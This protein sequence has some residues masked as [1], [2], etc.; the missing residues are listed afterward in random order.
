[1]LVRSVWLGVIEAKRPE[2]CPR[3]FEIDLA[4]SILRFLYH[5]ACRYDG[6]CDG[7]GKLMKRAD[8]IL[9]TVYLWFASV[10]PLLLAVKTISSVER[11]T[12]GIPLTR[13]IPDSPSSVFLEFTP[14]AIAATAIFYDISEVDFL[15]KYIK[16][17]KRS[18]IQLVF[19]ASMAVFLFCIHSLR[20]LCPERFVTFIN[21]E[22]PH[23]QINCCSNR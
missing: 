4:P 6:E 1:M 23:R 15:A 18:S 14:S 20:V 17:Y 5:Y 12:R 21:G 16:F 7:C 19:A 2:L 3:F 22:L 8:Y 10:L 11:R 9:H 13:G